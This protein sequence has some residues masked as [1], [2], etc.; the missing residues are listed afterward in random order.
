MP[1]T[2]LGGEEG[3]G[4][5]FVQGKHGPKESVI[6]NHIDPFHRVSNDIH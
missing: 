5:S 4:E 1:P 3:R 2:K 6:C